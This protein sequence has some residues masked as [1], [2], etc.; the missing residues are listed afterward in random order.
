VQYFQVLQDNALGN[1]LDLLR[2]MALNPMMGKYLNLVNNDKQAPNEKFAREML[3]LFSIGTCDLNLDGT[4][5]NGI[6]SPTFDN[7]VVRQYTQVSSDYTW[8]SGGTI[9][10]QTY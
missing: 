8:P 9:E 7:Q 6:Y 10:G 2:A 4:L 1:Y 5:K 3:Q